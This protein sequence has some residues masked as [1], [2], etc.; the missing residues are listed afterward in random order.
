MDNTRGGAAEGGQE[1]K[2]SQGKGSQGGRRAQKGAKEAKKAEREP[3]EARGATGERGGRQ[4]RE[5]IGKR[6]TGGHTALDESH[7]LLPNQ[8]SLTTVGMPGMRW[9]IAT[10]ASASASALNS[11]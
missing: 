8:P 2:H 5:E 7:T 6:A 3:E 1:K 9:S 10:F 11:L 4:R